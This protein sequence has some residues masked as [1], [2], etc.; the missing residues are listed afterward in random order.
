[1]HN[2]LKCRKSMQNIIRAVEKYRD[3]VLETERYIWKNPETGYKKVKTSAY[4]EKNLGGLAT[5]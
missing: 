2:K 3:T 1:M 4:M 5:S